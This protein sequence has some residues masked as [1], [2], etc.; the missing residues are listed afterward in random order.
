MKRLL[1]AALAVNLLLS[2][3]GVAHADPYWDHRGRGRDYDDWRE[4][5]PVPRHYPRREVFVVY[6][7][8]PPPVET[9]VV[10]VEPVQAVPASD[11]FTDSQGRYCREYQTI[12]SV[13]S[14]AQP[15]YGTACR[16][17]D[18]SWQIVR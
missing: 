14:T 3:A 11:P 16:M 2:G 12:V 13:G 15:A 8:P 1:L 10:Y 7:P 9:R 18:G 6:P 4:P 17:P 5:W